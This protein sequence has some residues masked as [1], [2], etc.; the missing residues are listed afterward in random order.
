MNFIPFNKTYIPNE[1]ND[2]I[3]DV[4]KS[5]WITTGP[6]VKE[7]EAEFLKAIESKN[8]A[9]AVSSGTAALHLA[10]IASGIKPGD[11]V[12]VPSF[13]FCSTINMLV[14][15]GAEPIFCDILENSLCIDPNDIKKKITSRTKAVVVVHYAGYPCEMDEIN[16][17]AEEHGLTV[18]EDAAHAFLTKYNGNY[19]GSGK[20]ITCFSFYATKNLTTA[21]GGMVVCADKEKSERIKMLSMHGIS[22]DG[23]NRYAELGSWRYDVLEPGYKY[24]MTDIHACIGL[25]QL[26]YYKKSHLRRIE[27]IVKYRELLFRNPY[28]ILPNDPVGKNSEHAW[29]LFAIRISDRS[30]VTRDELIFRL[31]ELK[32]GTSVHFIPNHQQSYYKDLSVV[33]PVTENVGN[34]ILSLPLYEL[35]TDEEIIYISDCINQILK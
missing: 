16:K 2:L 25:S 8:E 26:K 7:F 31:K 24:N 5:G 20:N 21:E 23:W 30:P 6:K 4:L 11:E 15:L 22:K 17:I 3:V 35:L 28:I 14:H 32:I 18:I 29:H 33:L 34:T 1:T 13:T 27:I 12:L 9:V 10:Y 19:I